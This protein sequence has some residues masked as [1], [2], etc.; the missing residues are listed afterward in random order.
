MKR[1][2]EGM[3]DGFLYYEFPKGHGRQDGAIAVLQKPGI[4]TIAA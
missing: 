2:Q 4:M 3:W 1:D